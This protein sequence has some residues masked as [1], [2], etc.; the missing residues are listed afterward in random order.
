LRLLEGALRACRL[1]IFV[2]EHLRFFSI[3]FFRRD[4]A[5]PSIVVAETGG[6]ILGLRMSPD[7]RILEKQNSLRMSQIFSC[8][9]TI[10]IR[11]F[12]FSRILQA[13]PR[14]SRVPNF[15]TSCIRTHES[16]PK[17]DVAPTGG[18]ARTFNFY[19]FW[20]RNSEVA[21][22]RRR[23]SQPDLD[24]PTPRRSEARLRWPY[25]ITNYNN[26]RGRPR[27]FELFHRPTDPL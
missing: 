11:W 17:R 20:S 7:A 19:K 24:T 6:K 15:K 2:G 27:L 4:P 8:I 22:P 21:S 10:V 5:L 12:C 3:R 26:I 16:K 25:V 13:G 18:F 1:L 23:C 9:R 14:N